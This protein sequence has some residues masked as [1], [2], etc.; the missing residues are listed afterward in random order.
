MSQTVRVSGSRACRPP[1]ACLRG[2]PR[3]SE[4]LLR[5]LSL[6]FLRLHDPPAACLEILGGEP[7]CHSLT[8][9]R[10]VLLYDR[11]RPFDTM[12]ETLGAQLPRLKSVCTLTVE[13]WS[14]DERADCA[15]HSDSLTLLELCGNEE[16]FPEQW[17]R[18][19]MPR[20]VRF[21]GA[22]NSRLLAN[23]FKG[24]ATPSRPRTRI[25]VRWRRR[26]RERRRTA[27]RHPT[28]RLPTTEAPHSFAASARQRPV[29][30]GQC[31]DQTW[32]TYA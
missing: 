6:S 17:P 29:C 9:L 4:T 2:G 32:S 1:I 10:L 31:L 15:W 19:S 14:G 12:C 11:D 28:R 20:L 22:G 21:H 23:A 5:R 26:R 13:A 18:L 24:R 27:R 16:Y 25:A 8:E 3:L 7:M 30:N